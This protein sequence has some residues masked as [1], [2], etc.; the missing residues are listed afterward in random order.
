MT[1][2]IE[3][4]V[5]TLHSLNSR[6]PKLVFPDQMA[7]NNQNYLGIIHLISPKQWDILTP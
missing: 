3:I 1:S 2:H 7:K 6:L 5:K 4:R